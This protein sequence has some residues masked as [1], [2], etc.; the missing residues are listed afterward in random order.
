MRNTVLIL[1]A[2]LLSLSAAAKVELTPLFTDNM[3]LHYQIMGISK[4]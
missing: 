4:E 3:V 1:S 2:L